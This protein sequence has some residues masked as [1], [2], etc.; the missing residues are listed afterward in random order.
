M[1]MLSAVAVA[2]AISVPGVAR[3]EE[4]P[5]EV[6]RQIEGFLTSLRDGKVEQAYADLFAGTLMSK[7]QADVDQMVALTAATT[8]FC[9]QIHDWQLIKA[10]D[11]TSSIY[12]VSYM[13][14]IG[15]AHV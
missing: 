5:A 12:D 10:E 3:A 9:G 13:I 2:V 6:I 8:R 14:Q 7:K 1:R 4:P 11:F 15:R